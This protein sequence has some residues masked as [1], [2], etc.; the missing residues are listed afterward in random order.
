MS[1]SPTSNNQGN[2]L[3]GIDN[4][5]DVARDAN[6]PAIFVPQVYL[7]NQGLPFFYSSGS[8]E[9][10]GYSSGNKISLHEPSLV[11]NL[12]QNEVKA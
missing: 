11:E 3:K 1:N 5:L 7:G 4:C 12:T 2:L 8:G 10:G 6:L 9:S